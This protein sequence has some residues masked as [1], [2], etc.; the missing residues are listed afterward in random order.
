MNL[1]SPDEDFRKIQEE[2][3]EARRLANALKDDDDD[4]TVH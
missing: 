1:N 2:I 3:Q 4:P